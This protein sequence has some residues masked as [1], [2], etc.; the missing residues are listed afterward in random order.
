MN[1]ILVEEEPNGN[2]VIG[3]GFYQSLVEL[4]QHLAGNPEFDVAKDL[5]DL[6][7]LGYLAAK[8][9][10]CG[11]KEMWLSKMLPTY[12]YWETFSSLIPQR[13]MDGHWCGGS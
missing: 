1:V 5:E 9:F 3:Y 10:S 6:E 11:A 7:R 12:L 2:G 13:V 4:N 8:I